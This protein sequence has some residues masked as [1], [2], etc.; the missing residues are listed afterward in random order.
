MKNLSKSVHDR[1]LNLSKKRGRA[2]NE[3]AQHYV[4]ERFLYRLSKSARVDSFILKG[5]LLLRVW[6]SDIARPTGD[7]DFLGADGTP[8]DVIQQIEEIAALEVQPDGVTFETSSMSMERITENS[9]YPGFRVR[10]RGLLGTT[11]L[12]MVLDA[13]FGDVV[14]PKARVEELLTLLE[15]FPAPRI[16]CYSRESVIAEKLQ[17]AVNL[18]EINSR[19]KDFFD[20]WWLAQQCRTKFRLSLKTSQNDIKMT[21]APL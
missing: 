19:M 9:E 1:L 12:P 17:A 8:E 11:Q 18:G 16:K 10:F 20:I 7:I 6:K 4:M 13:G 3:T 5:A 14:Y 15:D 2:F 21:G